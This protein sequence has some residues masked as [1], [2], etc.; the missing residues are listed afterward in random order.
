MHKKLTIGVCGIADFR[1]SIGQQLLNGVYDACS[2]YNLNIINFCGST[3]YSVSEDFELYKYY[4]KIFQYLNG[5]NIN[6]LITWASTFTN[7]LPREKIISIHNKL[8]PLPVVALG[9][10][11][12]PDVPGVYTDD[13]ACISLL[14]NHLFQERG[15][16]RIAFIGSRSRAHYMD[17]MVHYRTW[18]EKKGIPVDDRLIFLTENLE[19]EDLAESLEVLARRREE[20]G[21]SFVEAI[22]TVSDIAAGQIIEFLQMKGIRVP[23]DIAVTGY[24]NQ[25]ESMISGVPVTTVDPQFYEKGVRAV[26]ML[27]EQ[28]RHPELRD[29][30]NSVNYPARL[31]IRQSTG[32]FEEGVMSAANLYLHHSQGEYTVNLNALKRRILEVMDP[33]SSELGHK[34]N[35]E[36]V[37]A[38]FS[39]L[40]EE[41]GTR[42]LSCIRAN[43]SLSPSLADSYI[44]NWQ[45]AISVMRREVLEHCELSEKAVTNLE[46]IFHQARILISVFNSYYLT[47]QRYEA[48]AFHNIARIAIDLSTVADG[49]H[50]MQLLSRHVESLGMPSYILILQDELYSDMSIGRIS[51]EY[52]QKF[53]S[54]ITD[55]NPDDPVFPG[56]IPVKRL[57]RRHNGTFSYVMKILYHKQKYIGIALLESGPRNIA[58]YD[59]LCLLLSQ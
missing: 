38:L 59:M 4:P 49:K 23:E 19:A 15:F 52:P 48:Y 22:V 32:I 45:N 11:L 37:D 14:M 8:S 34:V 10:Q 20:E 41:K 57:M 25:F 35:S 29:A 2:T 39:D 36:L 55:D 46:N 24:N 21:P 54:D 30:K 40:Q 51:M 47:S 3:K 31:I 9:L 44:N 58:I 1:S 27:V 6:G 12:L 7:F 33:L 28:I 13:E 26:E 56:H 16:S 50:T 17:R 42:L 5:R 18:L 53:D 43:Y